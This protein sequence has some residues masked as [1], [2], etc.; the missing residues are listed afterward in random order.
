MYL[1]CFARKIDLILSCLVQISVDNDYGARFCWVWNNRKDVQILLGRLG[2]QGHDH[3]GA[4]KKGT[5][6]IEGDGH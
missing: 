5:A 1:T 3:K 6:K 4:G 2:T